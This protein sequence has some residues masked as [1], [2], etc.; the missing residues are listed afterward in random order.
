MAHPTTSIDQ[1]CVFFF[2]QSCCFQLW[3]FSFIF[4]VIRYRLVIWNVKVKF[5][6][7]SSRSVIKLKAWWVIIQ[8]GDSLG[9]IVFCHVLY[10]S[11]L[12][13]CVSLS[14]FIHL[15]TNSEIKL[16]LFH[17]RVFSMNALGLALGYTVLITIKY[18]KRT[19]ILLPL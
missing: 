19:A 6:Y 5:K 12:V 9:N 13:R 16:A 17:A 15:Y 3:P 7:F 10:L 8:F 14:W 1:G 11:C 2:G 4:D 18:E